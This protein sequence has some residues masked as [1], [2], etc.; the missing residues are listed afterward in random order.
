MVKVTTLANNRH[1]YEVDH[2]ENYNDFLKWLM[3]EI[4]EE[5][6]SVS[7]AGY[8]FHFYTVIERQQFALGFRVAWEVIDDNYLEKS[9]GRH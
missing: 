2:V 1:H 8:I 3:Y 5:E 9:N 4:E 6:C 7:Y